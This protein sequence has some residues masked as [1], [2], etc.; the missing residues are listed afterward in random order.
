M[1]VLRKATLNDVSL[2]AAIHVAAWK[3]TYQGILPD[4]VVNA[5][6][7]EKRTLAWQRTL[8]PTSNNSQHEVLL[9]FAQGVAVGFGS[10]CHQRTDALVELGY[11]GE[12]SAIYVL[13]QAQ[14]KGIGRRLMGAMSKE[15]LHKKLT[16]AS[17][18]VL[19]QNQD[20]RLFYEKM[21]GAVVYQKEERRGATT[22]IEVAYGWPDLTRLTNRYPLHARS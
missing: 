4:S 2:I 14:R 11:P 18:F 15:L 3:E 1:I 12:F 21:G 13:K 19:S 16:G 7:L 10:L 9:A 6:D 17:L 22:L 8:D 20:A 5:I